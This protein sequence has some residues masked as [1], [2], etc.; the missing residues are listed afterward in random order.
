[1]HLNMHARIIIT[2]TVVRPEQF[3]HS[4]LIEGHYRIRSWLSD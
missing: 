2:I 1:M 3:D 4:C